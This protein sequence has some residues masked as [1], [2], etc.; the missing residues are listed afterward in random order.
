MLSP[1]SRSHLLWLSGITL[2]VCVDTVCVHVWIS[3]YVTS[4]V[5]SSIHWWHSGCLRTSAIVNKCCSEH[6]AACVFSNYSFVWVYAQKWDCW[7]IWQL[8]VFLGTSILLFIMVAPI[9]IPT[10]HAGGFPFLHTL[11]SICYL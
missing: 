2:C 5:C 6:R 4:S 10:R 1:M 11:S 9:Y 7:I 3:L 8:L